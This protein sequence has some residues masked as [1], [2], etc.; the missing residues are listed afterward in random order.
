MYNNLHDLTGEALWL[1]PQ[2]LSIAESLYTRVHRDCIGRNNELASSWVAVTWAMAYEQS[3]DFRVAAE[4]TL[5][6]LKSQAG[7]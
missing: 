2:V 3:R 5:A 6:A 4:E 7:S 1:H